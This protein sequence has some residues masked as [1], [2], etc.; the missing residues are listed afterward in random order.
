MGQAFARALSLIG[1]RLGALLGGGAAG[2]WATLETSRYVFIGNIDYY[3]L[4]EPPTKNN[5]AKKLK[6]YA[7]GTVTRW[8]RIRDA[9]GRQLID[10][11]VDLFGETVKNAIMFPGATLLLTDALVYW[12]YTD[13]ATKA[14]FDKTL[15]IPTSQTFTRAVN[16][17]VDTITAMMATDIISGRD[18]GSDVAESIIDSFSESVL[19]DVV[20]S[21][22]D[23]IAGVKAVDDDE[24][25]DIVG[26][27][28]VSTPEELAYLGARSGL[29]TF[30]AVSEIYA[31]L[32]QGD[33]PYF[34][35]VIKEVEDNMKRLERGMAPDIY[36]YG[37][38]VE[39]LAE[40]VADSI[41]WYL[42]AVDYII[43]RI[44]TIVRNVTELR[45]SLRMG[46]IDTNTY[47]KILDSYDAELDAVSEVVSV[48]EN[49]EFIERLV[50]SVIASLKETIA[51][52]KPEDLEEK[53]MEILHDAGK[54]MAGHAELARKT[55]EIMNKIRTV[56]VEEEEEKE[57]EREEQK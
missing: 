12:L 56:Q 36:V 45:A 33:N 1:P 35:R 8:R 3:V 31:G 14:S 16:G 18:V 37:T 24:I 29:D 44:K 51:L 21:Y 17:I 43:N 50:S 10:Q 28:V 19:G 5:L 49:K 55:Y 54:R 38:I 34:N 30:S 39:R 7:K 11:F 42:E 22:L 27:G 48:L 40:D 57:E 46:T 2:A 53:I 47:N 4:P 20:K 6:E 26:E 9:L 32:L 15:N 23:T 41:Y 52:I 25:R 13:L